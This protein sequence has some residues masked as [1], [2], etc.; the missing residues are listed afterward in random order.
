MMTRMP[1]LGNDILEAV[2]KINYDNSLDPKQ[3]ALCVL[4]SIELNFVDFFDGD[5][6]FEVSH[7][8]KTKKCDLSNSKFMN[9][10]M[11]LGE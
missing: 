8:S 2:M 5:G 11:K 6:G 3:V 4:V 7:M 10:L 1:A 9:L